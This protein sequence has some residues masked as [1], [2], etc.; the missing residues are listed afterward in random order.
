MSILSIPPLWLN[1]AAGIMAIVL[2]IVYIIRS[3][4]ISKDFKIIIAGLKR[5][6][7]MAL[8][9]QGLTLC[10]IGIVVVALAA[11][12]QRDQSA[13]TVSFL[14]AGMLLVFGIVT[15]ST[16]GRS[17]YVLF[18]IGQFVQVIAAMMIFTGN[19]PR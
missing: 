6:L 5:V 17:E 10:F 16:G 12:G 7:S 13:K 9:W 3:G 11:T 14:C 8:L 1:G 4:P 15:G 2:G 19:L 18:R